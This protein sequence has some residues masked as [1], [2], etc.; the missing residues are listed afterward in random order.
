MILD[1]LHATSR[2]KG[3]EIEME[4]MA[5]EREKNCMDERIKWKTSIYFRLL[6]FWR[7]QEGLR[8]LFVYI[9][10]SG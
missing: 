5:K 8:D 10:F 3:K 2:Q 7:S 6:C 9:Q 4:R 1:P